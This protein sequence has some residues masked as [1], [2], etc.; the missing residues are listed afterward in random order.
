MPPRI[1]SRAAHAARPTPRTPT[2]NAH[3]YQKNSFLAPSLL[4]T[5]T[6]LARLFIVRVALILLQDATPFQLFF[7]ALERIVNRL[8][9]TNLYLCQ[10]FFAS[11]T[12]AGVV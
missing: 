1:S 9:L 12:M 8:I 6:P 11:F 3:R 5:P 4:L 10:G 2:E 7:E